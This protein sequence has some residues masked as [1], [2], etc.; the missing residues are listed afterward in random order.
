MDFLTVI[1]WRLLSPQQHIVAV[2]PGTLLGRQQTDNLKTRKPS[3]KLFAPDIRPT[4]STD[5][6]L[7]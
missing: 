6:F 2:K 1:R 4:E 7:E 5:L 3:T